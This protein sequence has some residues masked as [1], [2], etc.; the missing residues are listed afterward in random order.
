MK[1]DITACQQ[2]FTAPW[3]VTIAPL[4]TCGIVVLRGDKYAR[5]RDSHDPLLQALIENYDLW[6]ENAAWFAEEKR[7][8]REQSSTLFDTVAVYLAVTD[9]FCRMETLPIRV[10]DEGMTVVDP[11]AK[12]MRVAVD[13]KDLAAFENWLVARLT[14]TKHE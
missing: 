5:V 13:W 2:A 6:A 12:K 10:T 8:K 14:G 3:E 4:D 7:H 11:A 9:Q 1:A